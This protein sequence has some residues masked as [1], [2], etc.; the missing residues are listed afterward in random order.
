[1]QKKKISKNEFIKLCMDKA[2]KITRVDHKL[3]EEDNLNTMH[4]Y[5]RNGAYA[6][7]VEILM[8]YYEVSNEG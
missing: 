7:A 3:R 8:D 1:M 4:W 6:M 5:Y 2:E